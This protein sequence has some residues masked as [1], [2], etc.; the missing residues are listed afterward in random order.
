MNND[1]E[2]L[3]PGRKLTIAGEQ[4]TVGE[5]TFRQGLELA[6]ELD[7]IIGA[8]AEQLGA[9]NSREEASSVSRIL[10]AFGRH[11]D[12]TEALLAA[13]SG[14]P[15]EWVKQLKDDDGTALLMAMWMVNHAFFM[16]RLKVEMNA[17]LEARHLAPSAMES[18]SPH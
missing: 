5:F 9:A 11:P 16:S 8:I 2:I 18:S 1:T 14:Q 7:A 10:K 15:L 6:E 3:L 17:M 13:C 12:A 4:I